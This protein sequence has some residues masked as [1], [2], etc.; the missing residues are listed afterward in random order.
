[1]AVA[2]WERLLQDAT[3]LWAPRL[4]SHEITSTMHKYAFDSVLT[5]ADADFWTADRRLCNNAR[6]QG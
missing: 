4:G 5:V 2:L 6:G 1:M 3:T